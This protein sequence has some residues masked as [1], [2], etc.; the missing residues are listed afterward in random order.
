MIFQIER[1]YEDQQIRIPVATQSPQRMFIRVFHPRKPHTVYFETAPVIKGRDQIIVKIPK[2]PRAVNVE[3]YNENSGHRQVDSS[4]KIGNVSVAPINTNAFAIRHI[5]DNNVRS[6]ASFID[7]FAENAGILSAQ[8]SLYASPDGK[9]RIDYVDVIRDDNGRELRTP[10][11]VNTVTGLIQVA[12]RYFV[13]YTVPGRK[14]WLWH[15][16]SHLWRKNKREL[17]REEEE[18]AADRNAIMVYLGMGNPT[19]EAYNHIY[20]VFHNTPSDLN[21][22]RY[23]ELNL[24]IRNFNSNMK[25]L[26]AAA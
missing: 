20:K 6:F 7:D 8:N 5:V 26:N 14:M 9:F 21:R 18:M 12:K 11:R 22:K 19:V 17:P 24:L 25:Q 23:N 15:E 3:L 10:M 4:F 13:Q 2:M 16:Y 1:K